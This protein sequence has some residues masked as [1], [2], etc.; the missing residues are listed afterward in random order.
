MAY[1][2]IESLVMVEAPA[3]GTTFA[4]RAMLEPIVD[5]KECG[6]YNGPEGFSG[7]QRERGV[8]AAGNYSVIGKP[9]RQRSEG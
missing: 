5:A 8:V 2:V 7:P 9:R 3:W 4:A 6:L 1:L